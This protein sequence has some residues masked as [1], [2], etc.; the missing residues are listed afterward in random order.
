MTP[1]PWGPL[2]LSGTG[3]Y[4]DR[5][6]AGTV[7]AEALRIAES[8]SIFAIPNGGVPVGLAVA[9]NPTAPLNLLIV[10]KIQIPG[11]PEA[12]FGAVAPDGSVVL[13]EPLVSA[14]GLA[15]DTVD[16]LARSVKDEIHRRMAL[17]G[18]GEPSDLSGRTVVV[19]DDGLASGYT[20]LVGVRYMRRFSP[21]KVVVAVPTAPVRSLM[22]IA[23]EAD[24][25]VCPNARDVEVFAVAEAYREWRD[26]NRE[27][28]VEML[29]S[30]RSQ[31][32]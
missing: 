10:R 25:V 24:M 3:V 28:V 16:R 19:V 2:S 29:R 13:N 5:T 26:L 11:N 15:P 1:G 18:A 9:K 7:L 32:P 30:N 20:M 22:R 12:G 27:E 21:A 14:L 23:R 31:K 6:H 17:Y 8:V 4:R